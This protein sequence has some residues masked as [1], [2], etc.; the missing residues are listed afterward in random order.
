MYIQEERSP[1]KHHVEAGIAK[2]SRDRLQGDFL[3]SSDGGGERSVLA[4]SSVRQ[5]RSLIASEEMV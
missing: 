5:V 1:L 2:W 3:D 4:T